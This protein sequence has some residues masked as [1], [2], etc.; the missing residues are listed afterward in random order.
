[1]T[2]AH[3]QTLTTSERSAPLV[4]R[5]AAAPPAG[6]SI[7]RVGA[8]ALPEAE[9]LAALIESLRR[10]IFPGVFEA[11]PADEAELERRLGA[12]L[13]RAERLAL[14]ALAAAYRCFNDEDCKGKAQGATRVLLDSL[15][16]LRAA[17]ALDVQAAYDG[18]PAAECIEEIIASYPGVEAV[19]AYRVAHVLDRHGVP[20]AP[21]MICEQA[22]ARTGVDI[23]PGA[24]IGRSFFIDHGAGVVIGQ[25]TIVGDGVKLYQG[26]TLGAKS[27]PVD[28]RGELIRGQKRHPTLGDRVTVYAGAVVLGGDTVIGDDCVISGGVCVTESVPAGRIVRQKQPELIVREMRPPD[29]TASRT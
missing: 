10:I 17:L 11:P 8:S 9:T 24:K 23:H 22:H 6:A 27:F 2:S 4:Q 3:G 18:D 20:M 5:L 19:F 29:A 7:Q 14:E 12:E 25:T 21:R 26:V 16:E 15:P 13:E 1:M 28:E